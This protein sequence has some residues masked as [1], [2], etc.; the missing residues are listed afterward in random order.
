MK[1]GMKFSQGITLN[2]NY[3]DDFCDYIAEIIS[4]FS[5]NSRR[6]I[7]LFS[8][9][10]ILLF[11]LLLGSMFNRLKLPGLLGMILAGIL[12][13][14][15]A[16]NLVD[17][18]MISLSPSLRQFALVII[19]T[20]AGL[21]LDLG[22][23][24]KVGRPSLLMCFVPAS[25]EIIGVI[26]IAPILLKISVLDAAIMGSVL[27][28]V[29]PA[30]VVPRMLKL[31]NEGY[32]TNVNIPELILA[33][34]SVDDVFV[35]V[36]FTALTSL[37][38]GK[39]FQAINLLEI[40][41][42][43]LL[44]IVIGIMVGFLVSKF[45]RMYQM[46]ETIKV[47]ILLSI[48]FLLL[49]LE[50]SLKNFIPISGLLAIMSLSIMLHHSNKEEANRLSVSYNKLWIFAE[51]LLF[52]LVG[53]SLDLNYVKEAG[54]G[55]IL[56]VVLALGVRMIGVF[57]SLLKTSL[58]KKERFFCMLAYTPKA[59]V[60][61]AIGGIPLSMGLSSSRDILTIAVL[62]I[63]ITAP[64]GAISIDKTYKTLLKKEIK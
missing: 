36:I 1:M 50:S 57:V 16:L 7:M 56:V 62:A 41:I 3:A 27:A 59:T 30:V 42:S 37:S 5:A 6:N 34:S 53:I 11:G 8:L 10:I 18:T 44:G 23:L 54:I 52:V 49:Q 20:R 17:D 40:P 35:I 29:S 43:F 9:A 58:N 4:F 15:H 45:Y 2:R 60:Q 63:L 21:S 38:A 24:K 51:I 26:I 28:A 32:G 14:P 13:G 61:A 31:K 46:N 47:L 22:A 55:T 39:S 33:G 48:S 19:L 25:F 12:L 64:F